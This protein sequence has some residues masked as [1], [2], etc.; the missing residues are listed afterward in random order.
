MV[1]RIPTGGSAFPIECNIENGFRD[2]TGMTL[3]DWFAGNSLSGM[4]NHSGWISTI[5]DDPVEA[6]RR[7]YKIADAM[8]AEKLKA[9]EINA[10]ADQEDRSNDLW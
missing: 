10:Q 7:A 5:D 9:D 6:A 8:I 1:N 2:D 3:R 4:F